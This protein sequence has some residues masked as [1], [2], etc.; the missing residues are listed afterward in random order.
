MCQLMPQ[1]A[2]A[3]E[4]LSMAIGAGWGQHDLNR[5]ADL[6]RLVSERGPDGAGR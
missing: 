3:N 6:L 2:A 1:V 5:V 4:V